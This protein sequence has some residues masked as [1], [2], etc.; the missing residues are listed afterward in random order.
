MV[1]GAILSSEQREVGTTDMSF[2]VRYVSVGS[3][4]GAEFGSWPQST[5]LFRTLYD[6]DPPATVYVTRFSRV[7]DRCPAPRLRNLG[8]FS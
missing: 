6:F 3:A 2:T 4:A 1:F 7:Q 8:N 5:L